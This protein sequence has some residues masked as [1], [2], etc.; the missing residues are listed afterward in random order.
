MTV[1]PV[2]TAKYRQIVTWVKAEVQDG[3]IM[4]G[5]KLPSESELCQRF[6]VSRS[7]VRQALGTLVHEGWL[8]SLKG[9]GPFCTARKGSRTGDLALV[10]YFA[11]SYI[12]PGIVTAFE[13]TAQRN[14]FHMIFNQSE[15]DIEKERQILRKLAEKGVGGIAL[16]PA[17][18]GLD[19][20]GAPS[21]LASTNYELLCELHDAGTQI[22]LVDNNFGDDRFPTI[23]LDDAA[24][25][26]TAAQY[27]YERGHRDVGVIYAI[28]HRPFKLRRD[29]FSEAL[30]SFGL[31]PSFHNVRVQ[32]SVDAE[33]AIYESLGRD[34][35]SAFFC[36]NDELA[37]AL[38]K[39]A[40]RRGL[41]I[42]KDLSVI[43]VDNSDYAELPGICL[44]SISHPSAFI[45]D[46]SA[47]ILIDGMASPDVRFKNMISI[48]P[49]VVE[50]ASVRSIE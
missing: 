8:E 35:P 12:F 20:P 42:P 28:N 17:N 4:P 39:A 3:S 18:P 7:A 50:R 40:A 2:L 11:A 49:V 14:G 13:R 45:G 26:R 23:S 27:L 34:R 38:Y 44:T 30:S 16:V 19:E 36:A 31:D 33:E 48:D 6:S 29:G 41:T 43:S 22:L 9:I 21:D 37:V 24:V 46:R 5:D 15:S 25:G 1:Q 47:Q 32:R 10:C